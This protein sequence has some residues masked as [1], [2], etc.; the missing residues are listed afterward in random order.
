MA[1]L[2]RISAGPAGPAESALQ[3]ETKVRNGTTTSKCIVPALAE[4]G[5]ACIVP[6]RL[7][8]FADELVGRKAVEGLEPSGEG[9][10]GEEVVEV[11]YEPTAG[12]VIPRPLS[13]AMSSS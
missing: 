8:S 13:V 5:F 6:V 7:S 4:A 11:P 12:I 9:V 1:V 10:G 3:A 2:G